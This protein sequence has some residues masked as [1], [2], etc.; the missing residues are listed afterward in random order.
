M[1]SR[2]QTSATVTTFAS[3]LSLQQDQPLA[4]VSGLAEADEASKED[5]P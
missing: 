2:I 1:Q 5:C 4:Q 3:L